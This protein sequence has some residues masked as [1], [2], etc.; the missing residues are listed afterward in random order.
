LV[1]K[2]HIA[3]SD[4]NRCCGYPRG[5]TRRNNSTVDGNRGNE[6]KTVRWA[7]GEPKSEKFRPPKKGK[8]DLCKN[9][10]LTSFRF[11]GRSV[12]LLAINEALEAEAQIADQEEVPNVASRIR[13]LKWSGEKRLPLKTRSGAENHD[14]A[15]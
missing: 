7:T 4:G 11:G 10:S 14:L 12:A 2:V 15:V 3:D 9:Y 6:L 13:S 5:E 1:A 8:E